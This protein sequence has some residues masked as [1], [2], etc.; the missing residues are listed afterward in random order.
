MDK[1][2]VPDVDLGHQVNRLRLSRNV[3]RGEVEGIYVTLAER[4]QNEEQI[5]EVRV[6][7]TIRAVRHWIE[8][9]IPPVA[10]VPPACASW[11]SSSSRLRPVP[12]YSACALLCR[13]D[14][15]KD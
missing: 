12:P 8:C 6:Q 10:S 14:I 5:T 2:S 15:S 7:V 11:W 9:M 4:L 3:P 1:T 13:R